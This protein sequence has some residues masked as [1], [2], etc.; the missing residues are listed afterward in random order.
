[1]LQSALIHEWAHHIEFQCEAHQE[2]REAFALAQGL[3][4][5]VSWRPD[6]SLPANTPT[7]DWAGIPSEQYA[8]ATI[9]LVLGNRPIPTPVRVTRE[10]IRIVEKWAA[11]D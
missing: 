10:A 11:G 5:D 3:A 6:D 1:M 9:E 8:E 4:P 7:S 2:M